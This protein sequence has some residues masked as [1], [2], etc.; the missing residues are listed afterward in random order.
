MPRERTLERYWHSTP[1]EVLAAVGSGRDGLGSAEATAALGRVGPNRVG[2]VRR[3]GTFRL[4]LQQFESPIILI[5]VFASMLSFFLGDAVDAAIILAIILLSGLL[6]YW[7]ERSADD[8]VQAL[9]DLVRTEAEV[10]RDGRIVS[11]PLEEIVPGDVVLL[12][13]GDLV[14]GDGLILQSKE[15][16]VDEAALTGEAYPVEKGQAG[17]VDEA[18]QP[19]RRTN[20]VFSG[21]HVVSGSAEAVV[22]R[23]GGATELGRISKGSSRSR[24]R[25]ASRGRPLHRQ[26]GHRH[27]RRGTPRPRDG[28]QGRGQRASAR[29]GAPQRASADGLPEPDRRRTPRRGT[30]RD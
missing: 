25:R 28:R 16:L 2:R 24:R 20:C 17:A 3:A 9:L 11:L 7:R 14:P 19:A 29:R 26:D 8:A 12:N 15:L 10:R 6:G 13:A 5:L 21:T 1:E 27:R 4:L 18:A 23:T 30:G 22:V